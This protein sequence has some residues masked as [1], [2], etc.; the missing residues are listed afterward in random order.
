MADDIK[1][2]GNLQRL[3][4][5]RSPEEMEECV[6]ALAHGP[7]SM[8]DRVGPDDFVAMIHFAKMG[9][10]EWREQ[11]DGRRFL[12]MPILEDAPTNNQSRWSVWPTAAAAMVKLE[13][14]HQRLIGD[15]WLEGMFDAID[16]PDRHMID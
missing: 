7:T 16:D 15:G 10:G 14:E 8:V 5:L 11:P 13:E 2:P 6:G 9:A 1:R 4:V 12:H 3:W